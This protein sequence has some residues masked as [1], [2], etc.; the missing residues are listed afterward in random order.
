MA[1]IDILSFVFADEDRF[2]AYAR[3]ET[4]DEMS[5]RAK[6]VLITWVGKSVTALNRAKVSTDKA[7]VKQACEVRQQNE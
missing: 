2:Y 3:V 5:K 6:F 4:G 1:I 7:L